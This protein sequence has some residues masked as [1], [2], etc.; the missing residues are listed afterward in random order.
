MSHSIHDQQRVF[1]A[2][3]ALFDGQ[4]SLIRRQ[5]KI[6]QLAESHANSTRPLVQSLGLG[7]VV[8]ILK[9]LLEREIFSSE[10]KAKLAFPR[11]FQTSA[12]Q[13]AQHSRS[14]AGAAESEERAFQQVQIL[15][16]EEHHTET[17][18]NDH[19]DDLL[20]N[21]VNH[22]DDQVHDNEE[23]PSDGESISIPV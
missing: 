6:K 1:L 3:R 19:E 9:D 14:E 20:P 18:I 5:K 2:Y 12:A 8:A 13:E 11:L 10:L 22:D 15:D 23:P 21:G 17:R 16:A 7:N 4:N